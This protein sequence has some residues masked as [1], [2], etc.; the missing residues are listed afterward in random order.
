VKRAFR[1][2]GV[3]VGIGLL[4]WVARR[5]D[6]PA[7]GRIIA[8][9]RYLYLLPLSLL[10]GGSYLLRT[11]RW[12]TLFPGP[13]RPRLGS[14]FGALMSSY[15]VNNVLPARAGDLLRAYLLGQREATSKSQALGT[16]VVERVVDLSV[17]LLLLVVV[18]AFSALPENLDAT[19]IAGG[20][21]CS[22]LVA[23]LILVNSAGPRVVASLVRGL[24][25]LPIHTRTRIE[26]V[27]L[28]LVAGMSTLRGPGRQAQFLSFTALVWCTE[29]S[30]VWLTSSMFGLAL[31]LHGVLLVMLAVAIGTSVPA[32]PGYIGTYEFF[33]TS[34]LAALGVT[35]DK[36]LA[37]IITLHAVTFLGASVVGAV[38]LGG[39]RWQKRQAH[40]DPHATE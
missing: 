27:A 15:L 40:D 18:L 1:L 19:A 8:E 34:A 28:R 13:N 3:T 35:G 25:F 30:V 22:V 36:S 17:A 23:G 21:A 14:L 16:V 4:I 12:R 29:L 9:A 33:G 20:I 11:L 31:P 10:L 38:C 6:L 2:L 39:Q 32:A 26:Q 24:H 7:T 37:F 5:F